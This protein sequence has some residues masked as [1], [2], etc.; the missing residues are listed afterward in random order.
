MVTFI[1]FEL[2]KILKNKLN[3]ILMLFVLGVGCF[4]IYKEVNWFDHWS[5]RPTTFDGKPLS[6][7]EI[8]RY[9][10]NFQ[11][12]HAQEI[13]E[14]YVEEMRQLQEKIKNENH[15]DELHEEMM[16]EYY[17]EGYQE[18]IHHANSLTQEEYEQYLQ[19][20]PCSADTTEYIEGSGVYL[21]HGP[22]YLNEG[23]S[24]MLMQCFNMYSEGWERLANKKEYLFTKENVQESQKDYK[25]LTLPLWE[26]DDF[27]SYDSNTIH[28]ANDRFM[29]ASTS[30]DSIVGAK[31][32][33]HIIAGRNTGELNI[34]YT[35]I[36]LVAI[37]IS[38]AMF[39][40][41]KKIEPLLMTSKKGYKQ[42]TI[43]KVL[44]SIL[45]PVVIYV[46]LIIIALFVTR[47]IVPIRGLDLIADTGFGSFVTYGEKIGTSI[48]LQ[49]IGIVA[50]SLVSLFISCLTK[51]RIMSSLPVI[52]VNVAPIMMH[53]NFME[54]VPSMFIPYLM[55]SP[56]SYFHLLDFLDDKMISKLWKIGESGI[57]MVDVVIVVWIVIAI[58][59]SL[60]I[61]F[62]QR[63]HIVK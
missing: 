40:E 18:L 2:K 28:F 6:N 21:M 52:L 63:R 45:V 50:C 5:P 4:S 44:T 24:S 17:G 48:L 25:E 58:V 59:I 26:G 35:M 49:L 41:E 32:L 39:V 3:V 36:L 38:S 54:S 14:E 56:V 61:Y 42:V 7:V 57:L 9:I 51:S 34:K 43:A 37:I 27:N 33:E 29:N 31:L 60:T 11:H 46:V 12:E 22:I 53:P 8:Y 19:K 30:F 10:D 62:K 23:G 1:R 47:A 13:T 20:Y 55:G 16:I 15:M